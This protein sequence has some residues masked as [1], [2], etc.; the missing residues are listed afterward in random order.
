MNAY[1]A[2]AWVQFLIVYKFKTNY[3]RDAMF[4]SENNYPDFYL[5]NYLLKFK[6]FIDRI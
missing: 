1:L 6:D 2:L 3:Q 5:Y 4:N